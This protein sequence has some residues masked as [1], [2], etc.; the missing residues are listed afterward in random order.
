M[1]IT[2]V[3]SFVMAVVLGFS[4]AVVAN[5]APASPAPVVSEAVISPEAQVVTINLNTADEATLQRE[6]LGVGAAKAKA[7]VAYREA[8]GDFA[9]TDELMEVKGIG[10]AI[11]EKNRDKVAIN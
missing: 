3:P 6:L 1:R 11:F 2:L 8:N 5:T 4:G 7:I 10:K 9:S